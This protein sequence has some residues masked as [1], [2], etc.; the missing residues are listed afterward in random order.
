MISFDNC[1]LEIQSPKLRMG[2][3]NPNTLHVGGDHTPQSSADK[4]IGSLGV[5]GSFQKCLDV[6]VDQ[7]SLFFPVVGDDGL[8]VPMIM[9]KKYTNTM[10]EH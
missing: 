9:D 10:H 3:W 8:S 1:S 2:A 4:V 7:I 6:W 5:V